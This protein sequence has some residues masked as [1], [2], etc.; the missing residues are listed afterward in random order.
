[1][2]AMVS[3]GTLVVIV[4]ITKKEDPHTRPKNNKYK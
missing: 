2:A 3:G 4:L 1:V